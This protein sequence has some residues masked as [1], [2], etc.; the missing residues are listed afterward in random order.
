[1]RSIFDLTKK[2]LIRLLVVAHE[3][4]NGLEMV[5]G[6]LKGGFS[7]MWGKELLV[8][9]GNVGVVACWTVA[10]LPMK[11]VQVY[12]KLISHLTKKNPAPPF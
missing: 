7:E 11:F 1:L 12:R 5:C 2:F 8:K 3:M 10:T 6:A 9:F 4:G